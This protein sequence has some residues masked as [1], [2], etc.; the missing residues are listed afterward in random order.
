MQLDFEAMSVDLIR[1]L[2]GPRSQTAFARR[3]GY[4][5]NVV[6]TWESGRRWPDA[7]TFLQAAGRVGIDVPEA[8][9]AF[10]RSDPPWLE[11]HDPASPEGVAA[12]LSDLR[13][14]TPVREVAERAE[15]S[16]FAVSRWLRGCA[17]PR[18]P[19][20]LR[21]IEATSL[22]AVDFV[23]QFADPSQLPSTRR[24][25]QRQE[26]ARDLAWRL[27]WTQAVLLG[28]DLA[29]YR[30]L[31]EH[32]DAWLAARLGL[33][34]EEVAAALV[35]LRDA[36]Q[37]RFDGRRWSPVE[38]ATLDARRRGSG[39]ALKEHWSRVALDR[40]AHGSAGTF[41]YNLFTVSEA[42]LARIEELQRAH[43]RAVRAIVAES[44]P[45]E[46]IVLLNLQLVPLDASIS[47]RPG[48]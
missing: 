12:L 38:V 15:R 26:A 9:R 35:A 22:R 24:A 48:R 30:A 20:L 19:E 27:P 14:A 34:V 36:G 16:R 25:W 3:L 47:E 39:T 33:R 29:G 31:S 17:E 13:G 18:L 5:S 8:I 45:S 6:Y 37:A 7:S 43:Y 41:S 23:A 42:D 40:L 44:E 10:Y 11:D 1:A 21:M 32:D 4:R 46:R 2:R 28:L